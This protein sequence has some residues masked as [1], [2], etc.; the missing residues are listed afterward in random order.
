MSLSVQRQRS[1]NSHEKYA[2]FC[3]IRE[4]RRSRSWLAQAKKRAHGQS[5]C[6]SERENRKQTNM[7][8][9]IACCKEMPSEP[10][11]GEFALLCHWMLWVSLALFLCGNRDCS[12]RSDIESHDSARDLNKYSRSE[13]LEIL[14]CQTARQPASSLARL[15]AKHN[16]VPGRSTTNESTRFYHSVRSDQFQSPRCYWMSSIW[17][18]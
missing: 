15:L 12:L 4:R 14:V 17:A 5:V 6:R 11:L 16:T 1:S 7:R 3:A 18:H 2:L 8:Q 10:P 9:P 13:C